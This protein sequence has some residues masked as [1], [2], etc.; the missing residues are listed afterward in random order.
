MTSL[1]SE[2]VVDDVSS[3]NEGHNSNDGV[4]W[5]IELKGKELYGSLSSQQ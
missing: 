4:K 1:H 5:V 3:G 2:G